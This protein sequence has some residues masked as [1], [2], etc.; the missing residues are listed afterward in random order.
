MHVRGSSLSHP[1]VVEVLAPFIVAFW[2]QSNNEPLPDDVLPLH[3]ASGGTS[4]LK[5]GS[6]VRCFVLDADGRLLHWFNGFPNNGANPMRYSTDETAGYF[7]GEIRRVATGLQTVGRETL[8]KLPEAGNGVRLFIRLPGRGDA[9]GAPVVEAIEN[10]DEWATLSFPKSAREIDAAKLSRWLRLCYPAGVNEQLEPYTAVYGTLTFAP[11][12]PKQ[13]VL[14]G[15]VRM[16]LPDR[17]APPFE[18]TIQ[19]VLTYS[20]SGAVKLRGVVDGKYPRFDWNQVNW[21]DWR[22]TTAIE[23]RPD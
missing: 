17:K 3:Q 18:G 2:G 11:V 22:L 20:D 7:A 21:M 6:N 15:K 19:A 4:H 1:K 14:S 8:L 23:S 10:V 9:Y 5:T 16:D 13:A 12:G